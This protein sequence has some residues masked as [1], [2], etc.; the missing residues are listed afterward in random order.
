MIIVFPDENM[1]KKKLLDT[2]AFERTAA[3][4]EVEV[5][6]PNAPVIFFHKGQEVKQN[7]S[8]VV[9]NIGKGVYRLTFKN[10]SVEADEGEIRVRS[11]VGGR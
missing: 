4:F 3:V 2:N 6:D 5:T 8:C 1:F 11:L 7:D 10:C 9:E